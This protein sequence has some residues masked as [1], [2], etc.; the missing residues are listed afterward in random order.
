MKSDTQ[1][2]G[3]HSVS[4]NFAVRC[5]LISR[6]YTVILV[7]IQNRNL[8]GALLYLKRSQH[9]CLQ[10]GQYIFKKLCTCSARTVRQ[11]VDCAKTKWAAESA[12]FCL[13]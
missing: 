6:T 4:F 2:K 5:Q 9:L 1:L 3:V 8:L 13:R 12:I 10:T 11:V 7:T